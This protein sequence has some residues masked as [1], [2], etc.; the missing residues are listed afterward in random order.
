MNSNGLHF[1]TSDFADYSNENDYSD[2][3]SLSVLIAGF[4]QG[5]STI[6]VR[7]FITR[8]APGKR[9]VIRTNSENTFRGF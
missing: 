3:E 5:T 7:E 1:Y 2:S 4:P 9:F 6:D 8:I